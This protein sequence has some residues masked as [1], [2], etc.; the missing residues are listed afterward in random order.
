MKYR[1]YSEPTKINQHERKHH[2]GISV[3]QK[4]TAFLALYLSSNT[5]VFFSPKKK[6]NGKLRF[7]VDLRRKHSNLIP[8]DY[9]SNN[10]TVSTLTDAA[11]TRK[12]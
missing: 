9:I 7:F 4:N 6:P 1:T 10:H 3:F 5:Q 8:H 11:Q 2:K 12:G